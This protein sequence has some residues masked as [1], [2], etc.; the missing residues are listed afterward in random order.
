MDPI[1]QKV[2]VRATGISVVHHVISPQIIVD[3][4]KKT[5]Q[6]KVQHFV[7]PDAEDAL[8]H[9][10]FTIPVFDISKAE[11]SI[12]KFVK[13]NLDFMLNGKDK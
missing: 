13:D 3:L 10:R 11:A 1:S 6:G 2:K 7:S 9:S 12:V 4:D 5:C 8:K